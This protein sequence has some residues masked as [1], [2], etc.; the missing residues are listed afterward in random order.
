MTNRASDASR[1]SSGGFGRAHSVRKNV[2]TPT[3]NSVSPTCVGEYG[4]PSPSSV[5]VRMTS[6]CVATRARNTYIDEPTPAMIRRPSVRAGGSAA[7]ESSSST[8]SATS[9]VTELPVRIATPTCA[10]LS[11]RASLTPSPIIATWCP[12]R[13]S[14]ATICSF[15]SGAIRPKTAVG[16]HG[17]VE[18]VGRPRAGERRPGD[19]GRVEPGAAGEGGDG[20]GSSPERTLTATP[21]AAKPARSSVT[22][23]R[24]SSA[25]ATSATARRRGSRGRPSASRSTPSPRASTSTRRPS[26]V[27]RRTASSATTA[28]SARAGRSV[29]GA[30]RT[31]AVP[32]ASVIPLQ[33]SDERNSTSSTT[34]GALAGQ[35]RVRGQR[36]G[37]DV[38]ARH[39]AGEGAEQRPRAGLVARPRARP[40]R[41]LSR[42]VVSVPVLSVQTTSTWLT[43]ST[44]LICC[45]SAPRPPMRAAPTV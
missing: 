19:R 37:G 27:R 26:P 9:R 3:V 6:I 2:G 33:R 36:G 28:A 20:A 18:G 10:R 42:P 12:R 43:A 24:S 4:K 7:N 21:S 1:S 23:S 29:D 34:L 30:P 45:T 11:A 38:G 44:A 14:D 31:R 25:S 41:A 39:R 17:L 13:R 15:C 40:P 35:R 5:T 16:V 32:S 22:P 8:M